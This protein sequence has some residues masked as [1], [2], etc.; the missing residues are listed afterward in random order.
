MGGGPRVMLESRDVSN[1]RVGLICDSGISF[2]SENQRYL[3]ATGAQVNYHVWYPFG[4]VPSNTY[5][6]RGVFT[7]VVNV[8]VGPFPDPPA[9]VSLPGARSYYIRKTSVGTATATL[10]LQ[11]ATDASGS[12][13]ISESVH[14]LSAEY[15]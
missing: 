9:W 4:T 11:L 15:Q 7:N 2:S 1:V 5:W 10:T 13:V 12:N 8:D 3:T 14:N 6:I